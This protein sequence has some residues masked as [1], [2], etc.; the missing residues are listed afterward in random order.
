MLPIA[1]AIGFT[2]CHS[3]A[4]TRP[5]ASV[6]YHDAGVFKDPL[7]PHQWLRHQEAS[8]STVGPLGY[9]CSYH[10]PISLRI[11]PSRE[12]RLQRQPNVEASV[13]APKA[14][15]ARWGL[16]VAVLHLNAARWPINSS[17][18]LAV[19]F[20]STQGR[21]TPRALPAHRRLNRYPSAKSDGLHEVFMTFRHKHT[22][23]AFSHNNDDNNPAIRAR[24]R[25]P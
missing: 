9:D 1:K 11:L 22:A 4:A 10:K 15:P 24:W 21:T 2:L 12:R 3:T 7:R 25:W 6:R 18:N 19:R 16:K 17:Y 23:R 14:S 13:P 5:V 20:Q 8:P